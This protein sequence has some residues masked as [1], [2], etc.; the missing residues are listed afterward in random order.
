MGQAVL[1][2]HGI[3]IGV[4]GSERPIIEAKETTMALVHFMESTAG[5]ILRVI[6]GV[7]LVIL[8]MALGGAWLILSV[9]GLVPIAAGAFGFCLLGPLFHHPLRDTVRHG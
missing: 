9:V 6:A 5:R 7:A 1:P 4:S 3:P 2:L 8:G